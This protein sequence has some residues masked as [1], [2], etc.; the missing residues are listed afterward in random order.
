[1]LFATNDFVVEGGNQFLFTKGLSEI[2]YSVTQ[3]LSNSL[4][5]DVV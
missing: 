4:L 3:S 5:G 2:T 1:M